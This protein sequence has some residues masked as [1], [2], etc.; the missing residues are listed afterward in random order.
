MIQTTYDYNNKNKENGD[1]TRNKTTMEMNDFN[2][3]IKLAVNVK[4]DRPFSQIRHAYIENNQKQDHDNYRN[5][6]ERRNHIF[7]NRNHHISR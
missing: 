4:D 3:K 5:W 1:V 2:N 7:A 6:R